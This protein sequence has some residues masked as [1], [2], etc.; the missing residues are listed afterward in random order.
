MKA[1]LHMDSLVTL[2]GK[3]NPYGGHLITSKLV[4]VILSP[5]KKVL[6]QLLLGCTVSIYIYPL[7][8]YVQ[9]LIKDICMHDLLNYNIITIWKTDILPENLKLEYKIELA[10][11]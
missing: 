9:K 5:K 6:L 11:V 1:E 8:P 2:Y 4:C 3:I 10:R 7:T